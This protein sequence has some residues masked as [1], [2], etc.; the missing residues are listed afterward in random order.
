MTLRHTPIGPQLHVPFQADS[1]CSRST[2]WSGPGTFTATVPAGYPLADWKAFAAGGSKKGK[3]TMSC[4]VFDPMTRNWK[5]G[6]ADLPI[7]VQA[8]A[9]PRTFAV[10]T[11]ALHPP[12]FADSRIADGDLLGC[13]PLEAAFTFHVENCSD[14]TFR[15]ITLAGGTSFGYFMGGA[16]GKQNTFDNV[17]IIRPPMP[18][19][20]SEE[21][22][23][24][25]GADGFHNAGNKIGPKIIN[26]YFERMTDDGIAIHGAYALVSAKLNATSVVLQG[27]HLPDVGDTFRLY[28]R[29]FVPA[30]NDYVVASIYS[31]DREWRPQY[32][33]SKSLPRDGFHFDGPYFAL[34]FKSSLPTAIAF[35]WVMNNADRN[36]NG[37][38]LRN[39]TI[40]DHRARGM[41]IKASSGLIED[42]TINGSTLGGIV[43]TPELSWGE[44][45]FVRDLTVVNN[46]IM[47]VGYGK[48]SYGAIA[49]GATAY[50]NHKRVFDVGRGHRNVSIINN[51]ISDIETCAL[52]VTSAKGVTIKD[53]RFERVWTKN[54]WADCCPPYPIPKNTV[55]Y[56]TQADNIIASGNCIVGAGKYATTLVN[57]TSTAAPLAPGSQS[58]A[59]WS[60]C[61]SDDDA[62]DHANQH[63]VAVVESIAS[64][65][66]ISV[67]G[68]R[69]AAVLMVRKAKGSS[70]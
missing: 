7:S 30:T 21:P 37:F 66:E 27:S 11:A 43:I 63:R 52:W 19:G 18:V 36:G 4:N 61:K 57:I 32:N 5:Q 24:A 34:D 39:N 49:L 15:A 48:Q 67:M 14:S 8:T 50:V 42:C 40:H 41:L 47:H 12:R 20:A 38:I 10:D 69:N 59:S 60:Q 33:E 6:T 35:D 44:A 25:M 45:D 3:T 46:R 9:D 1:T 22:L 64:A 28:D 65:M 26:S 68:A 29:S 55:I 2:R 70:S 53:N 51:T 16:N 54:T 56:M 62:G 13:R 17:R 58:T 31:M 23:L